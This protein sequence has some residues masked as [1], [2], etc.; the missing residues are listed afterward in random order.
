M[1][2][3]GSEFDN[4]VL[5]GQTSS[6]EWFVFLLSFILQC[7]EGGGVRVCAGV[8]VGVWVVC[9]CVCVCVCVRAR[10]CVCV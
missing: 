1:L 4:A 3:G 5:H 7:V 10:V 6:L 8:C 2:L 9:V